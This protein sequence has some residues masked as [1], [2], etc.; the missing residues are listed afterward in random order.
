VATVEAVNERN[1]WAAEP[2]VDPNGR[3]TG[4]AGPP[5][6]PRECPP[7]DVDRSLA[8]GSRPAD[9]SPKPNPWSPANVAARDRR[10]LLAEVAGL[11]ADGLDPDDA[12]ELVGVD[13]QGQKLPGRFAFTPSPATIAA[14]CL[15][16]QSNWTT[17]ERQKRCLRPAEPWELVEA[18]AAA[19]PSERGAYS[20]LLR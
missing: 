11:V 6:D 4:Q 16:V 2:I 20:G 8:T 5:A 18:S 13:I 14:G 9:E 12:A 10:E 1:D 15:D 19:V 7:E 3:D 17:N